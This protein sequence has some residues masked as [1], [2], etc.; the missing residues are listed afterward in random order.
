[1]ILGGLHTACGQVPWAP[2][3]LGLKYENGPLMRSIRTAKLSTVSAP[4]PQALLPT[5]RKLPPS[6][7]DSP[8]TEDTR[9]AKRRLLPSLPPE[10]I[11][12]RLG[13]HDNGSQ[14][15]IYYITTQTGI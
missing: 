10:R 8:Y 11:D 14:K 4:T 15:P 13:Q 7:G 2:E 5:K 1:M 12:A 9:P 6:H 3:L